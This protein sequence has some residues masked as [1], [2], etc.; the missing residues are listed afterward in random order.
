MAK[1]KVV[2][3][4]EKKDIKP[5]KFDFK[6]EISSSGEEYSKEGDNIYNL[7][8]EFP[9]PALINTETN[10]KVTKGTKTIQKDLKVADARRC[11]TGFDTTSLE[12]LSIS[13][14]KQLA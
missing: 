13:I 3:K 10:I 6:V 12:L 5:K 9:A 11:F 14:S 1:E 2:K 8:K 7:L 4:E